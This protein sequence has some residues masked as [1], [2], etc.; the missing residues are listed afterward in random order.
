MTTTALIVAACKGEH[1]GGCP[2]KQYRRVGGKP[3]ALGGEI[4][5]SS[6]AVRSVRVVVGAGQQ[7]SANVPLHG[8]DIAALIEGGAERAKSVPNGL[9]QLDGD[10]VLV[11]DERAPFPAAVF[12]RLL[13]SLEFAE[14][15]APVLA[16]SDTLA[17]IGETPR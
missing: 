11:D 6:P 10:A 1:L 13:A 4:A 16:V 14:G 2:P 3:V 17:R 15:A 5:R 9:A 8:L 7:E 12:D